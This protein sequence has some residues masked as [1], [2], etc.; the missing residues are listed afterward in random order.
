MNIQGHLK[1]LKKRYPDENEAT[2]LFACYLH[3]KLELTL[4]YKENW[5]LVAIIGILLK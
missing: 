2:L 1:I 5:K 4:Q 3:D